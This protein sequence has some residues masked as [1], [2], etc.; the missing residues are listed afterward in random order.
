MSLPESSWE[1]L[2]D[3][4]D[5]YETVPNPDDFEPKGISAEQIGLGIPMDKLF[6]RCRF[7][8]SAAESRRAIAEG[9]L[10]V[11][12]EKVTNDQTTDSQQLVHGKYLLLQR[13]KKKYFLVKV[14]SREETLAKKFNI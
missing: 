9:S 12:K 8:P 3:S 11:N 13:G 10:S 5:H 4:L 7:L 6:W 14:L 1:D 2:F